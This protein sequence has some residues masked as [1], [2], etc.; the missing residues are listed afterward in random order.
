AGGSAVAVI[1]AEKPHLLY[2]PAFLGNVPPG[3]L[4]LDYYVN[5]MDKNEVWVRNNGKWSLVPSN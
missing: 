1:E 5:A 4:Y 2:R 3:E